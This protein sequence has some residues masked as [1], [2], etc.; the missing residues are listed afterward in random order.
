LAQSSSILGNI[1]DKSVKQ[2]IADKYGIKDLNK[3]FK[4]LHTVR[5]V[6][7]ICAHSG[8]LFDYTLPLSVNTVPQITFNKG[9]RNSLDTSIKV[10]GFFIKTISENRYND[11]Q[12]D[13]KYFFDE[14]KKD[15]FLEKIIRDRIKYLD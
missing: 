2:I 10:I 8:V 9:D 7:N 15:P 4:F 5:Q 11:F 3:F 14:R 1:K 12:N 6:R 13:I